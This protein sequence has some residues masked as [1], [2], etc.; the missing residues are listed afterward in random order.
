MD[1]KLANNLQ[2]LEKLFGTRML[3]YEQKLKQVSS[4]STSTTAVNITT[5]S[6]EFSDFKS[7]VMQ[8]LSAIKTQIELLTHGLDRHETIM[9]RKVLLVHGI[10]EKQGEKL[11]SVVYQ[12]LADKMKLPGI[13]EEDIQVCHRL[14]PAQDKTRPILVRFLNMEH[15]HLVWDNKTSLKG[16]GITV[17]EF[18]TKTRHQVFIAAREHFGLNRCWTVEGRIIVLVSNKVRRKIETRAELQSLV[19]QFPSATTIADATKPA[20]PA[21]PKNPSPTAA[22]KTAKRSRRRH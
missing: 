9:R 17:S 16:S 13:S 11:S 21:S 10:G 18:L 12:L 8:S 20:D 5:L 15:R 2:E 7:F 3:D 6:S 22:E 19:E 14:G 4:G 1:M